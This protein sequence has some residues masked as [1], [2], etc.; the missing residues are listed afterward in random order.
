[1]TSRINGGPNKWPHDFG[2]LS[3]AAFRGNQARSNVDTMKMTKVTVWHGWEQVE[4]G[5]MP[6]SGLL[7]Q[8]LKM[9]QSC[10]SWEY[11]YR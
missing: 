6:Q 3:Q 10:G 11:I 4:L 8:L 5:S 9:A 7:Y 2:S 1:M